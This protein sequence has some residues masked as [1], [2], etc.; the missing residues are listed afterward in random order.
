MFRPAKESEDKLFD[1]YRRI[2]VVSQPIDLLDPKFPALQLIEDFCRFSELLKGAPDD[3]SSYMPDIR[4]LHDRA[5]Q[6]ILQQRSSFPAFASFTQITQVR[7]RLTQESLDLRRSI[8]NLIPKLYNDQD[9]RTLM[10]YIKQCMSRLTRGI[11][12]VYGIG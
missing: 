5:V 4:D 10:Q 7:S 3:M 6:H 8:D 1:G 12:V 2:Q 11:Y 9:T